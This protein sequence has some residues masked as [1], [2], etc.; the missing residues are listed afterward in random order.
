M[1]S[2]TRKLP[3]KIFDEKNKRWRDF[4]SI[5]ITLPDDT[6]LLYYE[7]P[8]STSNLDIKKELTY[9][10]IAYFSTL[11]PSALIKERKIESSTSGVFFSK[12]KEEKLDSGPKCLVVFEDLTLRYSDYGGE[13]QENQFVVLSFKIKSQH[14]DESNNELKFIRDLVAELHFKLKYSEAGIKY[15]VSQ[16]IKKILYKTMK[17]ALCYIAE[18]TNISPK[19]CAE[20]KIK[21]LALAYYDEACKTFVA[22][23]LADPKFVKELLSIAYKSFIMVG[24]FPSFLELNTMNEWG[25]WLKVKNFFT[26]VVSAPYGSKHHASFSIGNFRYSFI[27]DPKNKEKQRVI[28]YPESN[29]GFSLRNQSFEYFRLKFF[30]FFPMDSW[31]PEI[32]NEAGALIKLYLQKGTEILETDN[33]FKEELWRF[34]ELKC[35]GQEYEA[36]H[37]KIAKEF[38]ERYRN[39]LNEKNNDKMF[40]KV[41]QLIS[42]AE[43]RGYRD[44][45]NNCQ[46]IVSELVTLFC[47]NFQPYVEPLVDPS[48][49]PHLEDS[50]TDTLVKE[51]L[52]FGSQFNY[53]FDQIGPFSMTYRLSYFDTFTDK[54]TSELLCPK[55][56]DHIQ[57]HISKYLQRNDVKQF[58]SQME[59]AL[60]TSSMIHISKPDNAN[61]MENKESYPDIKFNTDAIFSIVACLMILKYNEIFNIRREIKIA[62]FCEQE[63]ENYDSEDLEKMK[64]SKQKTI[65]KLKKS[66][67]KIPE[68]Y[69]KKNQCVNLYK[70]LCYYYYN[71]IRLAMKTKL[72][73]TTSY[74]GFLI[75]KKPDLPQK[76]KI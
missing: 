61:E 59:D 46:T 62:R 39:E 52:K 34:V 42:D 24:L 74:L 27:F 28:I 73:D 31:I 12:S 49:I 45:S 25:V 38:Y 69:A 64:K 75:A 41:T 50:G 21:Q 15:Q 65:E 76:V 54:D 48:K 70:E 35:M 29:R 23:I 14:Y 30:D 5:T 20:E 71:T 36:C 2:K 8:G 32:A 3:C 53:Q 44:L 40:R 11:L 9:D 4:K 19:L 17:Y 68:L 26:N 33:L 37:M 1:E 66:A 47:K 7:N 57:T 72:N 10:H 67:A 60:L 22:M 58:I 16:R 51:F 6:L 63:L 55:N 13:V 56:F 18:M 43:M